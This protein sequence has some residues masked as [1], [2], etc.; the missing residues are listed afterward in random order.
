[1]KFTNPFQIKGDITLQSGNTIYNLSL[2]KVTLRFGLF[3]VCCGSKPKKIV[4]KLLKWTPETIAI[5]ENAYLLVVNM[6][7]YTMALNESTHKL[8][9]EEAPKKHSDKNIT[10]NTKLNNNQ[11][12]LRARADLYKNSQ[13][14]TDTVND[15]DFSDCI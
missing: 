3:S 15:I 7:D 10:R 1:M 8:A 6:D 13:H 12:D 2:S 4:D 11:H 9:A 14:N 5:K